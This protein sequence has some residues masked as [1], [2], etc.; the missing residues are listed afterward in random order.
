M[1][2]EEIKSGDPLLGDDFGAS[3]PA[4]VV[5]SVPHEVVRGKIIPAIHS[6]GILQGNKMKSINYGWMGLGAP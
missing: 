3:G 1:G 2:K 6:R 5:T 4:P